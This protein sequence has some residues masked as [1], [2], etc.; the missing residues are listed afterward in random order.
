MAIDLIERNHAFWIEA[1]QWYLG[2][3]VEETQIGKAISYCY[4]WTEPVCLVTG[5]FMR[6]A[7]EAVKI[8]V[9]LST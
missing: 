3:A 2:H 9:P 7:T 5:S 8:L 1:R 4:N 6:D